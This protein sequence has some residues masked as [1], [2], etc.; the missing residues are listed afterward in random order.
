MQLE[1][2]KKASLKDK[3]KKDEGMKAKYMGVGELS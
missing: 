1:L 3:K 2:A